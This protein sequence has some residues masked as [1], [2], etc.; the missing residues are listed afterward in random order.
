[1]M[2]CQYSVL[3]RYWQQRCYCDSASTTTVSRYCCG[4]QRVDVLLVAMLLLEYQLLLCY[5]FCYK[6]W[7]G[8]VAASV[9]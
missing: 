3:L 6:V 9:L 1:M 2:D 8:G 7:S 4:S 5:Y